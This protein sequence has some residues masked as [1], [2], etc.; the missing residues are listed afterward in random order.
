M[1]IDLDPY[2]QRMLISVVADALYR[3]EGAVATAEQNPRFSRLTLQTRVR[4]RDYL[5]RIHDAMPEPDPLPGLTTLA[6]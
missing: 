4:R 3:A 5:K 1:K 6:E 2:Q